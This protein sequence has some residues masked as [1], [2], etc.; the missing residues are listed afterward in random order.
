MCSLRRASA[1]TCFIQATVWMVCIDPGSAGASAIVLPAQSCASVLE[2][3]FAVEPDHVGSSRL[4][5][6]LAQHGGD[7]ASVIRTVI[8]QVLQALPKRLRIRRSGKRFEIQNAPQI[9]R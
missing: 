1:A 7:L 5:A 4:G 6:Q 8:S 2:I 3:A 9:V